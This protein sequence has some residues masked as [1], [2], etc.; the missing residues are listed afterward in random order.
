MATAID[1]DS[2]LGDDWLG[3][4]RTPAGRLLWATR[5]TLTNPQPAHLTSQPL[6]M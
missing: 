5:S 2:L 3:C 1:Y 6:P 4:A